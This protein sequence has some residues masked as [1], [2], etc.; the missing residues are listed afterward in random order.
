MLPRLPHRGYP[1]C[2]A[3]IREGGMAAG[4]LRQGKRAKSDAASAR[5]R[6]APGG[7]RLPPRV[8][9]VEAAPP[10][11]RSDAMSLA[12]E[13]ER[14]ERELAAARSHM[15]ELATRADVDPLTEVLNRRGFERE[16]ARSLAHVK[17]Y[18]TS[19]ALICLDLDRFK[20]VNDRHGHAAGDAV[21]K[22]VAAVVTRHVRA[23]DVV[24]RLGGDEVV[25]LLWH[26][27]RAGGRAKA[28]GDG[29]G[30]RA[31]DGDTFRAHALGRR[32]GRRRAAVAA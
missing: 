25:V 7:R 4:E 30:D 28:R 19:A 31:H 20:P 14:L 5:A 1:A 23:S 11:R 15:A 32:V 24:A 29:G 2:H 22:A 17:R 26:R 16:L 10:A 9:H 27:S 3:P 21:L 12:V 13:V 18:G 6:A 8:D